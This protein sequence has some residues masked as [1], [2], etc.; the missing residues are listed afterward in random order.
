MCIYFPKTISFDSYTAT[1]RGDRTNNVLKKIVILWDAF[2][3]GMEHMFWPMKLG[4]D[5]IEEK[6]PETDCKEKK[7]VFLEKILYIQCKH[8]IFDKILFALII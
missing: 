4:L 5:R 7:P 2:A 1:S 8:T 3:P 6:K